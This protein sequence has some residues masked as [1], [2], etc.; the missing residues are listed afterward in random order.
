MHPLPRDFLT[1]IAREYYL[2]EEQT[3]VF[4][5][6]FSS[7]CSQREIAENL[8]ISHNALRTRMTGVYQKFSFGGRVP[9]KSRKLHDFLFKKYQE[10]QP[11][12]I[13]NIS[14]DE[15]DIDALVA[16]VRKKISPDIKQRCGTM[17]VLDMTQPIGLGDIYTDVN[18]LET[19]TAR[20][21]K[22]IAELNEIFD[23]SAEEFNRFGL[24]RQER[25]ISGLEAVKQYP[26][27]MVWGKP[28]A[29]KTTFLKYLAMQCIGGK[30]KE[31]LVPMFITLKDFAESA[32]KIDL[33]AY[34]KINLTIDNENDLT[35]Y[36]EKLFKKWKVNNQNI[37]QIL[38]QGKALILL[39]GL[40][41]VNEEHRSQ[42]TD[43]IQYFA[44]TNYLNHFGITCRIAAKEYT[45]QG[46]DKEV[47]VADFNEQQIDDFAK[48]WFRKD[49]V[50]A[51]IFI[52]K[53]RENEPIKELATNPLLLTLLC[54]VFGE[55]G[56]FP[57]NRGEL[58]E[59]G[60][61]V[62]LKK[63]DAKRNI[64]RDQIYKKLSLKRKENL[65]SNIAFTT[66]NNQDYFF[67]QRTVEDYIANYISNLPD[68]KTDPEALLV[69]SKA[70]LKSIEAQ[71]GL[72]VE[73]AKGIYSF[74]HLTFQEYFTARKIVESRGIESLQNLVSHIT[75]KRWREVFFLVAGIMEDASDLILFMK[76]EVDNLVAEDEN[77]QEFL[78]WVMDKSNSVEHNNEIA[79]VR[80][81][82]FSRTL[83]LS[84]H[85]PL[86]LSRT[87]SLDRSLNLPLNLPLSLDRS[88]YLSL[89]LDLSL[90]LDRSLDRSRYLDPQLK[91]ALQKLKNQ[92]PDSKNREQFKQWWQAKG[93]NWSKE[94]REVMIK[95]RN[96]GYNWQ[97]SKEQKELLEQYKNANQLLVDCL[98]SDCY[99]TKEVRQ[100]IEDSLLLPMADIR[101]IAEA[102]ENGKGERE[103]ENS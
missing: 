41:E 55:V 68:A 59:E 5:K 70:V 52:S 10:F 72:L 25:R 57:P 92:L 34:N 22:G 14:A 36:I 18:I 60:V 87:P 3:E 38:E 78:V 11:K 84:L 99:I 73:R 8:H 35:T 89:D 56:N 47:E 64:E 21:R 45:F 103:R 13:P 82:Y 37:K 29:G 80:A 102:R 85:F 31:N 4:V 15:V 86:S 69:D 63:W 7:K 51:E 58:Y 48:K 32:K 1:Q 66:F 98:N 46:F 88:R 91:E 2:S 27:L 74:S 76:E 90:N 101:H 24:G 33:T 42:V 77:I 100:E 97:F 43:A 20:S 75:E 96:I 95:Y 12:N 40:D 93:K 79:A 6:L 30:F 61:D 39:D 26:K 62:L 71:H 67:K 50:K 54:L 83:S 94:L 81:L 53:L 23:C 16:E 9:N 17:Q 19:I 49:A 28:G 44:D 65:L